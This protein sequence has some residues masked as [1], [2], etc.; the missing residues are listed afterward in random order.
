[1]NLKK[2]NFYFY[3]RLEQYYWS[4]ITER[5]LSMGYEGFSEDVQL[6]Y[7]NMCQNLTHYASHKKLTKIK[8]KKKVAV[9]CRLLVDTKIDSMG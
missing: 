9:W 2:I 1:M 3:M 5:Y 4:K 8:K 6:H 7:F